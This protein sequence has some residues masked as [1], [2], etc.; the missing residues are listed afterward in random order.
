MVKITQKDIS[1]GK[2]L[3]RLRRNKGFTQEKMAEKIHLST[4]FIGL[5]ETGRRKA[6]LKSLQKIASVLGI[7]VKDLLN[8]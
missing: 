3:A 7:K 8:F 6:S 4:T 1:F 2:R 5:L